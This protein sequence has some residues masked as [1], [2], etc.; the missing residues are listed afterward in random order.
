MGQLLEIISI[1][2]VCM[3]VTLEDFIP[4]APPQKSS[5]PY[6]KLNTSILKD[7]DF[8]E[9]FSVLYSKLQKKK[10]EYDDIA[11]WW[12]LCAKPGIRKFCMGVS[13]HLAD[14]RKDTKKY[15][16]SYLK[17]VLKQGN[18]SEVTQVRWFAL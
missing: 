5:S 7:E 17:L 9:N 15:L 4:V 11:D 14:V 2:Y 8:L 16:F 6:W 18:W 12:D 3:T 10:P 13:S 1:Q